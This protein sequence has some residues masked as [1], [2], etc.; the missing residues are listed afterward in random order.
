MKPVRVLLVSLI[1]RT[2]AFPRVDGCPTLS[3]GGFATRAQQ[4]VR[5]EVD[6]GLTF[7]KYASRAHWHI[8]CNP[9]LTGGTAGE[10]ARSRFKRHNVLAST[11]RCVKT[12]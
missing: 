8:R 9:E 6:R 2:G 1:A 4:T 5:R 12:R 7:R 3:D 10:V 11:L